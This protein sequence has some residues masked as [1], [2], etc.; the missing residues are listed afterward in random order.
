MPDEH[1][2]SELGRTIQE[3]SERASLLICEEIELAKAEMTEKVTKLVKGAVVGIV[4]GIFAVAA[5]IYL[6]HSL[7]WGIFA[8]ISDDI[9]F[10]W[11]GYLIAAGLLL[12]LVPFKAKAHASSAA[13]TREEVAAR[14]QRVLD[15][16]RVKLAIPSPVEVSV[17]EQNALAFS[18]APPKVEGG[19]FVLS[20]EASYL[21]LLTEEELEA[22]GEGTE[23]ISEE[24]EAETQEEAESHED[25]DEDSK[26]SDS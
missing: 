16:L 12:V 7:S 15:G 2:T 9:N 10:V 26:D 23:P 24:G 21:D 18:V 8:L 5:L 20:I 13:E 6:I 22:D 17:V 3:V 14:V 19:A 11:L 1:S 25:S 4:A